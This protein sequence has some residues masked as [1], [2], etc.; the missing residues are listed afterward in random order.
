MGRVNNKSIIENGIFTSFVNGVQELTGAVVY[1]KIASSGIVSLGCGMSDENYFK[2]AIKRVIITKAV[3]L[4]ENFDKSYLPTPI[5]KPFQFQ[6]VK[7]SHKVV[8]SVIVLNHLPF[9]GKVYSLTGRA[10]R[11]DN[12]LPFVSNTIFI[13]MDGAK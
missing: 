11:S 10:I 12:C 7:T 1:E 13:G 5:T 9:Y 6:S 4:P 2:G 8:N 3:L